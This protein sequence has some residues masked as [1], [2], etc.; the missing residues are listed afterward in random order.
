MKKELTHEEVSRVLRIEDGDLVWMT[1]KGGVHFGRR[2]TR[3]NRHG[4]VAIRIHGNDLVAH[5]VIWFLHH[6]EWPNGHLDHIDLDKTN[7]RIENLR[8]ATHSQ[9]QGNTRVRNRTGFKGVVALPHEKFQ[10]A[11][12]GKYLGSFDS[13]EEAARAYD[14]AAQAKFGTFAYLNFKDPQP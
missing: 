3:L 5:R 1:S 6:G 11:C 14:R 12:S 2:V 4:Y 10:A 9:N 13:P 7:N 8:L